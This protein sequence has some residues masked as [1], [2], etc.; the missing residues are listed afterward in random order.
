ME[1]EAGAAVERDAGDGAGRRY[2]LKWGDLTA[3]RCVGKAYRIGE[4]VRLPEALRQVCFREGG[5][6]VQGLRT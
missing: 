4:G 5:S 3:P 2:L 6:Y 1:G